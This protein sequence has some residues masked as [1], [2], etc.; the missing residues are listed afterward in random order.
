MTG[1]VRI[2]VI[3]Y[4]I[5][6]F[7]LFSFSFKAKSYICVEKYSKDTHLG[8]FTLR[9]EGRTIAIGKILRIKPAKKL[10]KLYQ[11]EEIK[12]E[13]Q[14]SKFLFR[15]INYVFRIGRIE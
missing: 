5:F 2:I 3:L 11:K 10:P 7:Y 12:T 4:F 6:I 14:P 13:E 15:V 8:S 1:I 9:D